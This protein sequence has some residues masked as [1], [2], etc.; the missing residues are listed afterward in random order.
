M[1]DLSLIN[2]SSLKFHVK[3]VRDR[4]G[5][6]SRYAINSEKIKTLCKWQPEVNLIDGIKETVEHFVNYNNS[7]KEIYDT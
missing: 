4:L 2:N 5:H 3:Y 1:K 6:D 7:K